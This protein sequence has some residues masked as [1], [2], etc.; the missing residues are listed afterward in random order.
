MKDGKTKYAHNREE[1]LEEVQSILRH[2]K[3]RHLA[4]TIIDCVTLA[5]IEALLSDG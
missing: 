2:A 3:R 5:T 1:A 4:Y